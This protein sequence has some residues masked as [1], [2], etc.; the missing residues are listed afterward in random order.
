[1]QEVAL[2]RIRCVWIEPSEVRWS[3]R[4]RE[5]GIAGPEVERVVAEPVTL[6]WGGIVGAP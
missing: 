2:F 4:P 6:D 1:L 3:V 5:E